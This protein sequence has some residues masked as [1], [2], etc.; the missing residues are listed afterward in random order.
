MYTDTNDSMACNAPI[1][2]NGKLGRAHFARISIDIEGSLHLQCSQS[3]ANTFQ[4]S[5]SVQLADTFLKA[6][7]MSEEVGSP[8]TQAPPHQT[9]PKMRKAS[10]SPRTIHTTCK[11]GLD[12]KEGTRDSPSASLS[13]S[14]VRAAH[15]EPSPR[16]DTQSLEC[17]KRNVWSKDNRMWRPE[18][19]MS[20]KDRALLR[21]YYTKAFHNL[22]Q[23]NC[24]ALAKAYIKLVEPRKQV[25]FPYN[26]RVVVGGAIRQLDPDAAKPPW[27]PPRVRHREP[28]HLLKG[29]RIR[30]L[31]HILCELCTSHGIT[32]KRLREADQPIRRYIVPEERVC[33]LDEVYRVRQE[34][35]ESLEGKRDGQHQVW[36]CRMNLPEA[37]G[38]KSNNNEHNGHDIPISNNPS[39]C[40][41]S[42]SINNAPP[43]L[44]A[45][46]VNL[47]A[48]SPPNDTYDVQ[49]HFL[50]KYAS[51]DP[52]TICGFGTTMPISMSPQGLKRKREIEEIAQVDATRHTMFTHDFSPA[53]TTDLQPYPVEAHGG[54]WSSLQQGFVP[55]GPYTA[56]DL[57]QP[58]E[59][60]DI[61]YHFGYL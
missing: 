25:C 46:V 42:G 55:A 5:L 32:T 2:V 20:I 31:V 13:P 4:G 18:V 38:T 28:D 54:P 24:R 14:T 37:V 21:N 29:E 56:K 17:T 8:I 3:I 12:D 60:R 23:T 10:P 36:I 26:G 7:A 11:T 48:H 34:E 61:S 59:A 57:A 6:I 50:G 44:F 58:N 30:L 49:S 52:K 47:P 33:I 15:I 22:Q 19:A 39:A 35:V 51:P 9:T 27:W 40:D 43:A 45:P 41:K 53:V 1:A 16:W